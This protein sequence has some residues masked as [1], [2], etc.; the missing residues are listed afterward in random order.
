QRNRVVALNV[1]RRINQRD[2]AVLPKQVVEKLQIVRGLR[3]VKL[4][5]VAF[6]EHFPVVAGVVPLA[7]LIG[8]GKIAQPMVNA[9]IFFA[10]AA[11]PKAIYQDSLAIGERG[12]LVSAFDLNRHASSRSTGP[13]GFSKRC[14]PDI[15]VI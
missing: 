7:Q 13:Q 8:G 9:G 10:D 6:L 11:W 2:E 4:F 15:I 3:R 5:E 1:T 12:F 14:A